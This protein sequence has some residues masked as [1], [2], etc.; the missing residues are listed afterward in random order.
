M[1]RSALMASLPRTRAIVSFR[2]VASTESGPG[3]DSP[4]GPGGPEE[5]SHR[6]VFPS[7]PGGAPYNPPS[8]HHGGI[9]EPGSSGN[10]DGRPDF[11]AR[12]PD[13]P[14]GG[15]AEAPREV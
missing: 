10:P 11:S 4:R 9:D 6:K 8:N 15:S 3:G 5:K 12:R 14:R 1:A 7:V 13:R 2:R